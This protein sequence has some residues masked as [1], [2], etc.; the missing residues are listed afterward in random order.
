MR[1][2]GGNRTKIGTKI[3]RKSGTATDIV[4]NRLKSLDL[5]RWLSPI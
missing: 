2:C 1:F 5:N 3:A 4:A